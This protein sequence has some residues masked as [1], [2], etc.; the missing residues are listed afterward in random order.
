MVKWKRL[1][2]AT[3]AALSLAAAAMAADIQAT[4][5]VKAVDPK[6]GTVTIA[7]Q[8]ISAIGWPAMTMPFKVA[9]PALL[10]KLVAGSR[11]RFTLESASNP[12][13]LSLQV[14]K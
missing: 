12:R 3:A 9:D 6:A 7:H 11:I 4:G 14:V 5:V 13:I 8:P 1:G 10:D 2:L